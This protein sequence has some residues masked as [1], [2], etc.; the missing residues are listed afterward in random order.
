MR[1]LEIVRIWHPDQQQYALIIRGALG[2]DLDPLNGSHNNV[3]RFRRRVPNI[4]ACFSDCALESLMFDS[5]PAGARP[6]LLARTTLAMRATLART[7]EL[8]L[9]GLSR[10]APDVAFEIPSMV[11]LF[12][13]KKACG[14]DR[15]A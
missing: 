6:V 9:L 8:P 10:R 3:A 2:T 7:P 5:A 1:H 12:S 13:Q 14:C 4:S 15:D 11:F